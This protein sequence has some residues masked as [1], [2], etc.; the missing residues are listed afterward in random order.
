MEEILCKYTATDINQSYMTSYRFLWV[1]TTPFGV[2][3][4]PDVYM[5]IAVLS[6]VA[7]TLLYS[8]LEAKLSAPWNI[9]WKDGQVALKS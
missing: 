8:L 4:D 7:G 6:G 5:T 2:P 3:V 1:S 9:K